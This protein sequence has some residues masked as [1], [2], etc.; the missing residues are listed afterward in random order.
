MLSEFKTSVMKLFVEAKG[1]HS[2][3][4]IKN[5]FIG[6]VCTAL[7]IGCSL[8]D[9]T[10]LDGI[11][12]DPAADTTA[13]TL[14]SLVLV[15][16]TLRD[17]LRAI[18]D[19][20]VCESVQCGQ[21][22]D[23][24]DK[25]LK[26][27]EYVKNQGTFRYSYNF[28]FYQ[29]LLNVGDSSYTYK[30][31]NEC[32]EPSP[33]RLSQFAVEY[34]L[35]ND[36]LRVY[37]QQKCYYSLYR[38]EGDSLMGT[39]EETDVQLWDYTNPDCSDGP[40][41]YNINYALGKKYKNR[42]TI[43]FNP[44]LLTTII[45]TEYNCYYDDIMQGGRS[46]MEKVNCDKWKIEIDSLLDVS[47]VTY[48]ATSKIVNQTIQ[49]GA[50]ACTITYVSP[51]KDSTYFQTCEEQTDAVFEAKSECVE[52]IQRKFCIKYRNHSYCKLRLYN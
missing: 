4:F 9:N 49:Y 24:I 8:D 6:A 19:G 37:D 40:S 50:E 5:V 43:N 46:Y 39:W 41:Y 22:T 45:T 14:D 13:H 51:F 26:E 21:L 48:D 52:S 25:I 27:I 34:S 3:Y 2:N 29:K 20:I 11:G 18:P 36:S 32:E 35:V 15:M 28:E 16:V 7:L 42:A 1:I 12:G 33:S 47:E 17:S 23:S 10:P 30:F 38:G 31:N 44:T